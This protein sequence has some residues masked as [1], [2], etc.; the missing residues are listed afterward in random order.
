MRLT[1][2]LVIAA[3]VVLAVVAWCFVS[4]KPVSQ[5]GVDAITAATRPKYPSKPKTPKTPEQTGPTQAEDE[6]NITEAVL[7]YQFEHYLSSSDLGPSAYFV[8]FGSSSSPKD[9]SAEFL[10]RF[11]GNNP[12]VKAASA[13]KRAAGG[14]VTDKTTNKPGVLFRVERLKWLSKDSAEVQGGITESTKKTTTESWRAARAAG[15]WSV[16]PCHTVAAAK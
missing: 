9:P 13:C 5:I 12:P 7:R 4:G 11:D 6:A 8:G 14:A 15:S 1:A 10:K 16:T 3:A 2:I